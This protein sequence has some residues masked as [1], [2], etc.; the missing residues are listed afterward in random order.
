MHYAPSTLIVNNLEFDHADIFA[1]LDAIKRQFHHLIR[2]LPNEA[3][4]VR[5]TPDANIDA[6]L[7][8]GLWS[9]VT[10]FGTGA[11]AAWRYAYESGSGTLT[12]TSPDGG[13]NAGVS[14]L[15]GAHNAHNVAA[16]VA[17]VADVGLA[18]RAAL[19]AMAD[20]A[21]VKRRLEIRGE[22]RGVV[23]YDDFAHHPTAIAA[24][25]AALRPRVEAPGRI[26]AVSEMRSNTMR[27]GVHRDVLAAAFAGAER[28]A[29][30]A[31][32]D[33]PWDIA[34][35]FA[36]LDGHAIFTDSA[37]LVAVV[38]SWAR[39]GDA[40]LVMSNGGFD[41]VHARLLTALEQRP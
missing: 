23:V 14:P 28:T 41:N 31:P 40:I 37:D 20:F 26:I 11:D 33:L 36:Q 24:T 13:Q 4:I 22:A 9:R 15:L 27:M 6:V 1:D 16:A 34:S 30:L 35:A 5:P 21:N 39:A 12:V 10:C 25:I 19:A 17:A 2:T 32:P 38:S 8:M 3:L 18:P 29:I 7:A